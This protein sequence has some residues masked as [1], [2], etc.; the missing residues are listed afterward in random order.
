MYREGFISDYG[1]IILDVH[2]L[3]ILQPIAMEE[4]LDKFTGVVTNGLFAKRKA[5]ILLLGTENG[6]E[7]LGG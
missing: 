4:A 7:Q 3:Q 5:D 6:V 1:N 2:N